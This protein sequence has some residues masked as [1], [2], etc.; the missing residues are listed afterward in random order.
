MM[1]DEDDD[2]C[3]FVMVYDDVFVL[4]HGV[5]WWFFL[6]DDVYICMMLYA[7]VRCCMLMY[8]DVC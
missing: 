8:V 1:D 5:I 7:D 3:L 4:D 2:V 6:L